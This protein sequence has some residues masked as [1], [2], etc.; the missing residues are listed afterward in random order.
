M[1]TIFPKQ[2]AIP[3][4][5]WITAIAAI[6]AV[7]VYVFISS[8]VQAVG[9]PLDDAW[10]HQTY[11]RNLADFGEWAFIPGKPTAGSTAP[12]WTAL[13]GLLHLASK[14]TP[15]LLTFGLGAFFLGL[16]ACTAEW[17][18]RRFAGPQGWVPVVGIFL[19]M[20]W[21]LVWAGASGMETIMLA[22]F[23]MSI[24]LCLSKGSLRFDMV[25][26]AL[27]GLA[28]WVRPDAITLMGPIIFV[29]LF[30]GQSWSERLKSI[31]LTLAASLLPIAAFLGFNL[32]ISGQVWPNTFYAKQAEYAAMQQT[33]FLTRLIKL[34]IQPIIGA[35]LLLVPGF[36]Y[37]LAIAIKKRE[38]FWLA[39]ILWLMGFIFIY[40]LRLPVTY[41]HGRYLMPAM[42]VF[43]LIGLIGMVTWINAD[44]S[45]HGVIWVLKKGWIISVAAVQI[46]FLVMGARSYARDVAIINTEMV[47]AA[48]WIQENTDPSDLIAVHDI[49]AVGYY[50]QRDV[51]DLAGLV[52]PEVIP[53]I[54]NE[55]A[56]KILLD[57]RQ[58]AYLMT[59]PD[60]Y[61]ELADDKAVVFQTS[62]QFSISAGGENMTVYR[63]MD[64]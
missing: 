61:E 21:H 59:F 27:T 9:F 40:A 42:P 1:K 5:C 58:A 49:G 39:V 2:K 13:L 11:A 19:V 46:A 7:A 12:L 64:D 60:W 57:D 48:N 4:W 8:Q 56:L 24:F 15:F 34:A 41:Q 45:Q 62:S 31:S 30:R 20:E 51:I 3:A 17:I 50:S 63:W 23:V 38:W 35:G 14:G 37:K 44:P 18:Y 36:I 26:G 53:V 33:S 22:A 25:A 47:A 32:L 16:L 52:T 54:R 55:H 6:A 29:Q 28:I 10:I 43:F